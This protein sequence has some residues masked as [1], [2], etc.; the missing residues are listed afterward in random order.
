VITAS[1]DQTARIW[2]AASGREILRLVGHADIVQSAAFS[3]D[4]GRVVTSS[5]D[6]TARIWDA[7][8]GRELLT[9][10]GHK[11]GV[12]DAVYSPDGRRIVTASS[13][14][15]V[16]VWDAAGG[17][18]IA[19]YQ[20]HDDQV[21]TAAFSPDGSRII[22][23]S[24]DKTARVW[25][26][27]IP[28]LERQLAWTEA[29]QFDEL[30]SS[31]RFA[32]GL[33]AATGLREWPSA[34]VTC[35]QLAAAPYD[36][37][38]RSPGGVLDRTAAEKAIAACAYESDHSAGTERF[39]YEH[40]RA[41]AVAGNWMAA[42]RDFERA[43]LRGYRAARIDLARLLADRS[44]GMLTLPRAIS[45]YEAAWH[46]GLMVAAFEL[47]KLYENG[48]VDVENPHEYLLPPDRARAW[49]WYGKGAES[50]EPNAL[51][52][53]GERSDEAAFA[54][55]AGAERN[56]HLLD[57]FRYFAAAAAGARS[58]GWPDDAWSSW[59]YRR[60]SLAR[61]LARAGVMQEVADVWLSIREQNA[62]PPATVWDRP[63]A[64]VGVH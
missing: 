64:S 62:P 39:L 54:A 52:R 49:L 19:L 16:R 7:T 13:D 15:T 28:T 59:R 53:F 5:D 30:S 11:A 43:L 2:D 37:D 51:A 10:S 32:L 41:L 48:V 12:V 21:E 44:A 25:N 57:A 60:A 36:P 18:V 38:R 14:R 1:A 47:G 35:D 27:Y 24:L 8:T 3:P 23:A 29:A 42:R 17:R 31:E 22:S 58:E 33:P 20:G 61:L 6:K 9:L 40:G 55:P 56:A 34:A 26:A 63:A 4:G 45:L 50:R 46:D